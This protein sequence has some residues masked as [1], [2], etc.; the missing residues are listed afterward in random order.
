MAQILH[1]FNR[2][3]ATVGVLILTVCI[4]G[5]V[6]I[7]QFLAAFFLVPSQVGVIRT[8]ESILSIVVLGTSVGAPTLAIREIAALR[9]ARQKAV[10]LKRLICMELIAG[11]LV[12]A[13]LLWTRGFWS[14]E[15]MHYASMIAGVALLSNTIRVVAAF[16][17][18]TQT[19]SLFSLR[20]VVLT[21]SSVGI[22]CLMARV[23]GVNGWVIG[24]YIGEATVLVGMLLAVRHYFGDAGGFN[25]DMLPTWHIVSLGVT[26][27]LALFFRLLCDNLPILALA[28][29][30]IPTDQIGF[31][32]LASLMLMGPNLLLS[33]TAQV[34]LPRLVAQLH[35]PVLLCERFGRLVR[36]MVALATAFLVLVFI[37]WFINY[38]WLALSYTPT[39]N[40]LFIMILA[41]PMRA[42]TLSLGTLIT[43]LGKYRLFVYVNIVEAVITAV[44]AY[45]MAHH[46]A[47]KGVI[48]LFVVGS[49]VSL[50]LH[51]GAVK[52]SGVLALLGYRGLTWRGN[53]TL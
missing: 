11:S 46:F 29:A 1:L 12:A 26:A 28:A 30:K 7:S 39:I 22:V 42:A 13:A 27:N 18:G 6:L 8:I 36:N 48:V 2:Y 15:M 50:L 14:G 52:F 38:K 47:E 49:F 5:G 33:V 24:R 25:C 44:F 20:V 16:M 19:A 31:F 10:L 35:T 40:A 17:Q 4:Q 32:G 51:M 43:A 34:E 37:A 21:C 53:A 3:R 23:F 41:L 9:E 45:P